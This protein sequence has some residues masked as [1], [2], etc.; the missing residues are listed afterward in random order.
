MIKM[1]SKFL[2]SGGINFVLTYLIYLGALLMFSYRISYS[3]AYLSGIIFSYF[4]NK[5]FVF[6]AK[7]TKKQLILYPLIYLFQYLLGLVLGTVWVEI[8]LLNEKWLP[9]FTTI[10]CIPPT[11][12]LMKLLFSK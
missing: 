3:I 6:Q 1:F 10:I 12:I 9:I 11:F 5:L 4:I 7:Y 8:F 2:L